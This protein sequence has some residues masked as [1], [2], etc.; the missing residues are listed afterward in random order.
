MKFCLPGTNRLS[1]LVLP[2]FVAV[3]SLFPLFRCKRDYPTYVFPSGRT[4]RIIG[5]K[6]TTA[7]L[8]DG[9]ITYPKFEYESCIDINDS[10]ALNKEL[11]EVWPYLLKDIGNAPIDFLQVTAFDI[12]STFFRK[13]RITPF[14][15]DSEGIWRS[16]AL[17]DASGKPK[18]ETK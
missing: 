7:I 18:S 9:T 12:N 3:T 2:F 1:R 10:A 17:D 14:R 6:Q 8:R 5:V 11:R 4:I 15:K 13:S 16:P